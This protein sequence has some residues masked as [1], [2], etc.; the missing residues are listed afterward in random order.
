MLHQ[1]VI[2]AISDAFQFLPAERKFVFN[3]ESS[4][5]IKCALR[6]RHI[7]DM[8]MLAP[9]PDVLIKLQPFLQPIRQQI[10]PLL[11]PAKIFQLHLFEL[12]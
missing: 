6:V 8:Q 11:R 1:I 2:G 4:F 7:E 12:A 9:D 3:I 5:G 10:H